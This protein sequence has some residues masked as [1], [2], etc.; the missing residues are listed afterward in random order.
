MHWQ[1]MY[2]R[3]VIL[4][5][6]AHSH[7]CLGILVGLVRVNVVE[8]FGLIGLS[9]AGSKVNTHCEVDLTAT[10]DVV[11]EGIETADLWG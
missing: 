1:P 10:H 3:V 8:G 6:G 11:Q 7:E 9:V 4:A 5:D 2:S